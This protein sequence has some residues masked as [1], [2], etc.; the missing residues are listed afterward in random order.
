MWKELS[1]SDGSYEVDSKKGI[2]LYI[3]LL[4]CFE[5]T[6]EC[7]APLVD[8]NSSINYWIEI[9]G[10]YHSETAFHSSFYSGSVVPLLLHTVL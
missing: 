3:K 6:V 2:L 7:E 5:R 9:Y 4:T 1:S 10:L 8:H